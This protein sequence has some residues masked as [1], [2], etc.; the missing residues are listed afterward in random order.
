MRPIHNESMSKHRSPA[1]GTAK[2]ALA[3]SSNP[4]AS[5]A[6]SEH[7]ASVRALQSEPSGERETIPGSIDAVSSAEAP[8][9][10]CPPSWEDPEQW[11][12]A[13]LEMERRAAERIAEARRK[14]KDRRL[15]GLD[16]L[17][18][19]APDSAVV[20][21]SH[22]ARD[23]SLGE[24]PNIASESVDPGTKPSLL[25]P[26]WMDGDLPEKAAKSRHVDPFDDAWA[27]ML[28]AGERPASLPGAPE[29]AATPG[30]SAPTTCV[31]VPADP[32]PNPP[33]L[34]ALPKPATAGGLPKPATAGGLPKPATA[35]G[36]PKPATAGGLPKPATAGKPPKSA[37]VGKPP[38]SATHG[39]RSQAVVDVDRKAEPVEPKP[40]SVP[41]KSPA[42]SD[43]KV[44]DLDEDLRPSQHAWDEAVA[45]A[46]AD[47]AAAKREAAERA[48]EERPT[49]Q[50]PPAAAH[51]WDAVLRKVSPP[52][53]PGEG[54][55]AVKTSDGPGLHP[56]FHDPAH[57]AAEHFDEG[58][59]RLRRG[60]VDGALFSWRQAVEVD[61]SNRKYQANLRK[62]EAKLRA[63]S[64]RPAS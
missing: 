55:G 23:S 36:L 62:L 49:E 53:D 32:T 57:V 44:A 20:A 34:G 41:S 16:K 51:A 38:K 46:A 19:S 3:R 1:G 17:T 5:S 28:A 39:E 54:E 52:Q 13:K 14:A 9:S 15:P 29:Q 43:P 11:R 8:P 7:G 58:F 42:T 63:R 45:R 24:E 30:P 40:A 64:D 26:A 21:S 50:Q 47:A 60:D 33:L 10:S 35:G 59:A 4:P 6:R 25:V 27:D 61:P 18:A 31:D 37:T 22:A 48:E 12:E 2:A 56:T